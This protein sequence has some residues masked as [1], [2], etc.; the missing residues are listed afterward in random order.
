MARSSESTPL[1]RR[2]ILRAG[3]ATGAAAL[4]A[5]GA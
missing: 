3:A 2:T 5:S 4:L 1:S